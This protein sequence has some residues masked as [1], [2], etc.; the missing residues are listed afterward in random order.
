MTPALEEGAW[1][2]PATP[3]G[4]TGAEQSQRPQLGHRK[5][6]RWWPQAPHML[7]TGVRAGG[8]ATAQ[9]TVWEAGLMSASPPGG[10]AEVYK[11]LKFRGLD[12]S[13]E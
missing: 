9:G 11:V 10:G 2:I 1:Q 7:A 4:R 12:C 5:G 3:D 8:H 6:G 13:V